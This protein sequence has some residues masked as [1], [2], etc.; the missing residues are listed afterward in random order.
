MD[1]DEGCIIPIILGGFRA[2]SKAPR[3]SMKRPQSDNVLPT[4]LA[5]VDGPSCRMKGRRPH[6]PRTGKSRQKLRALR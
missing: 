3:R 5:A 6:F 2:S 4:Q 1:D